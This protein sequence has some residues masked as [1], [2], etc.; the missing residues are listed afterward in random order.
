MYNI[1]IY[2]YVYIN[3]YIYIY[4]Y[5]IYIYIYLYIYTCHRKMT[6][7]VENALVR[8]RYQ[9]KSAYLTLRT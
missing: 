2:T 8:G 7:S 5:I 4:T 6:V 9:E 3:I 1:H